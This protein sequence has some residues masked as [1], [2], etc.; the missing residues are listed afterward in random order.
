M[1][2]APNRVYEYQV[3]GSLSTDALTYVERQADHYLYQSLKAGEFCYVLNSRQMGKSS[4][5]VRTMQRLQQEGFACAAIDLTRI[6]SSVTQAQWYKG[7][8]Y[9]LVSSFQLSEK[10]NWKTWWSDR[11]ALAPVQQFSEFIQE[12]LLAEVRQN[13]VIFIDEID[14][15]LRLDFKDDFFTVIRAC[16]NQRVDNPEYKRLTFALLGVATPS[17]LIQDKNRTPFNIGQAIELNGFRLD[18]AQLLAHGLVRNVDN[19][20]VVLRE[21]WNW[22]GGQPFLIQ[23]LCKLILSS[24]SS[25]PEGSEVKWVEKLVRSQ[26]IENWEFQDEPEHLRT[27]RDRIL[28]RKQRTSQMLRLYQQIL[29]QGQITANDSLAQME[30]RLS[31][32]VVKEPGKLRVYNRIYEAVFDHTWVEKALAELRPYAEA[33]SAWLAANCQDESRLLRGQALQ[34]ALAWTTGKSLSEQDYQFLAASQEFD[35]K[36]LQKAL[37]AEKQASHILAEANQTLTE[38]QHK[39]KRIIRTALVVSSVIFSVMIAAIVLL[40]KVQFVS[41]PKS[42]KP[43]RCDLKQIKCTFGGYNKPSNLKGIGGFYVNLISGDSAATVRWVAKKCNNAGEIT[44]E[45]RIWTSTSGKNYIDFP[46]PIFPWEQPVCS[47]KFTLTD[48][49]PNKDEPDKIEF[50]TNFDVD[51]PLSQIKLR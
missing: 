11:N 38:A 2:T 33:I 27:I 10:I 23:K 30:L 1:N 20:E 13:V 16:Y 31:G 29:Q 43:E 25:I 47:F 14:S 42:E 21:V 37:E 35:K 7:I 48:I 32:L 15:V 50:L 45:K 44:G 18:E 6:G 3:G 28:N 22:T 17:D 40:P 51:L 24:D 26:V 39:A 12:V 4:L 34:E 9:R 49:N 46:Y 36:E 5:R 19:P 8:V 41:W